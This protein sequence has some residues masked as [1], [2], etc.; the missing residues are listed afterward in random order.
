MKKISSFTVDHDRLCPGIYISRVDG[1]VI[2]YDLRMRRP[3]GGDYISPLASHS[4]EHLLATY[5]RMGECGDSVIYVGP[6]GCRTGFY[7]LMRGDESE[8]G[9]HFNSLI[10]ALKAITLHSGKVPGARRREC[11]NFRALSLSAAKEEARRY[12]SVLSPYIESGTLPSFLYDG[13]KGG[14]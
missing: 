11:G 9:K 1:D 8:C 10:D 14:I 7:L 2:T 4:F 13:G 3:N 6:M 12:L 5:M